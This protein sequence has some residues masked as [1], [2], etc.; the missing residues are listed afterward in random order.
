M[1]NIA[2]IVNVLQSMILT[3]QKDGG[4]MVLTPTY[5]VFKMYRP[6]QEATYLP[7]DLK[8][9]QIKVR[10]DMRK[11]FDA[12]D[13]N[14]YRTLPLVSASAAKTAD[15]SIVLSLVNV[16]TDKA[17]EI[18]VNLDDVKVKSVEGQIL[19]SKNIND[20]NDF[21]QPSRV[22]PVAFKDAKL[23]KGKLSVKL[24]KPYTA[25]LFEIKI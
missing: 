22:A 23:K 25:R 21:S 20:Y 6:F 3:D 18:E 11:D 2:Q 10:Y 13:E 1:A 8:C 16:S 9:E 17:K 14:T 12:N 5:Y 7:L 19:T 24:E 4:H 15:G